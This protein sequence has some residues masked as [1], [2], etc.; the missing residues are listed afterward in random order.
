MK[1]SSLIKMQKQIQSLINV[2]DF[3]VKRYEYLETVALGT[4]ETL[5]KMPGYTEAIEE[6]KNK[7]KDGNIE[8][9]TK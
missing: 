7:V 4:L 2:L 9:D 5:K 8:Q 6:I 1:E 3:N